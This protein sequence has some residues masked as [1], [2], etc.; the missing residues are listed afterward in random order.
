MEELSE[1][2]YK[3]G[4]NHI[5]LMEMAKRLKNRILEDQYLTIFL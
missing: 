4:A 1:Y 5:N 2:M 3:C